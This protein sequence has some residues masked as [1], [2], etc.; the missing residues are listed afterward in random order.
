[1]DLSAENPFADLMNKAVKLKG[2]Q[3]AQLRTQ[4]DS[5]PQYFQHSLFMQESVV[6]VRT[7]PFPERIAAA[8][9]MKAAG[10]DHF[11]A[12]ANE[13]A[14]AEYEKALAVF[15]YLENKDP[16]WKKKGIEDGDML[17]TDFKCD[18]PEDQTRLDALK[19]SC[20]LNIA[21]AKFKLKEYPVCVRACDDTL[22]IDPQNVKAYYRR[23][24]ALI[25]P[26]SSGALEFDRAI[27]DLQK[28]YA[29][30]PE[31]RGVRKLLREL[32]EQRS[33]QRTL[34]KETF[35]G[36]FNRGQVYGEASKENGPKL[37]EAASEKKFQQEVEEAEALARGFEAK[38]KPEYASEIR[39]KIT[40][41]RDVRNR[42][43]KC[44][45]FFNPTDEMIA[46][47]K[48]SGIDLTDRNVQQMLHDLQEEERN[49]SS[50]SPSGKQNGQANEANRSA[51]SAVES[52]DSLLK[53]MSSTEIAQLLRR[54]GIDYHKISDREQFLETAR[55]VL[56]AKLDDKKES[57]KPSYARTIVLLAVAWTLLRLYTSGGL[58]VLGRILTNVITG[59]DD[60]T[61]I[62]QAAKVMDIFDED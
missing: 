44:V 40:Q 22:E 13:E 10:N 52:V 29:I 19:T 39:E 42:R 2:A 5:W 62:N 56:L 30:D 61:T 31:N 32:M 36:M 17:V 9:G 24:Q 41:A 45:D 47:A 53:S 58:S 28:A 33:K 15:K 8:E 4:F 59:S 6:T 12:E 1:M 34:D 26:A 18:N 11:N 23:A 37:D 55:Q 50:S 25:T 27:S 35:S 3:Q 51:P 54:E 49:K 16:G 60:A 14:V 38:G 57:A 48:E 20:Y 43:H 7:N 21:V 46:N